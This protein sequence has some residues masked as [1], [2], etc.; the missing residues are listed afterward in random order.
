MP[1]VGRACSTRSAGRRCPEDWHPRAALQRVLPFNGRKVQY[2]ICPYFFLDVGSLAPHFP[3]MGLWEP[4]VTSWGMSSPL[5]GYERT[6]T[7]EP[8][9]SSVSCYKRADRTGH[10][11]NLG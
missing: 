8:E 4:G 1:S 7:A 6:N 9:H 10:N 3:S 5:I 11:G 2:R